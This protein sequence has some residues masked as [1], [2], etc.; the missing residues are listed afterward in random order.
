MRVLKLN[1]SKEF[2]LMIKGQGVYV[3]DYLESDSNIKQIQKT[4]GQVDQKNQKDQEGQE[5]HD[6]DEFEP[7]QEI[8]PGMFS[9]ENAD[10][11]DGLDIVFGTEN[12]K[13]KRKSTN[14]EY[15]DI[16]NDSGLSDYSGAYYWFSLDAQNL[17]FYAGVG[18]PRIETVEYSYQFEF[19]IDLNKDSEDKRKETKQF[20][21]SIVKIKVGN[22][23]SLKL[24]KDPIT[25]SVPLKLVDTNDITMEMLCL[26]NQMPVS[27]LPLTSQ[28]LYYS[29]SGPKIT[30]NN[31]SFPNFT[32]AIEQSIRTPGLWC[33]EKLKEKSREFNKDKPNEFETYLRITL[34]Q[35]NGE[36][37]GIPYVMEIWPCNHYS[38][39]HSHAGAEA[40]IRVL[41][42]SIHVELYPFLCGQINGVKPF[43]KEDFTTEEYTWVSPGLNQTHQLKNTDQNITCITLNC[44]LYGESN[45]VHYDYFNYVDSDGVIQHYEPDSDMDFISFK[46]LM[47]QEWNEQ[48]KKRNSRK[49][50]KFAQTKL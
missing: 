28:K 16:N 39:I 46:K 44:Y 17:R 37:P 5:D 29:I 50:I 2:D 13:V 33:Y 7:D 6:V 35:N 14:E 3:F 34:G 1:G 21:E 9:M 48:A 38:P 23:K 40:I 36:S 45:S 41:Y 47:K 26:N 24:I 25:Q 8:S 15:I 31:N 12:I 22:T 30:L 32:Q 43:G 42:G 10:G 4:N 49:T 11:S 18:E 19:D 20:L 27:N